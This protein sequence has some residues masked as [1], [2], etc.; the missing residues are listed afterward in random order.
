[1][2]VSDETDAQPQRGAN[3]KIAGSRAVKMRAREEVGEDTDLWEMNKAVK[4]AGN[5]IE[6]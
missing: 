1:V 6:R 4:I 2:T 3:A 5:F